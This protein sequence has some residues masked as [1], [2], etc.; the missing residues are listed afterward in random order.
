MRRQTRSTDNDKLPASS[1]SRASI[2]RLRSNPSRSVISTART[3]E[4]DKL[5]S[6]SSSRASITRLRSNPPR[7]VTLVVT[8]PSAASSST[9]TREVEDEGISCQE[10]SVGK[11]TEEEE[12]AKITIHNFIDEE[13][14][15]G[16]GGESDVDGD[17]FDIH[18]DSLVTH[19]EE[20]NDKFVEVD[21][22]DKKGR[23]I[24]FVDLT[25]EGSTKVVGKV[26]MLHDAD[27]E[28]VLEGAKKKSRSPVLHPI[29]RYL[30]LHQNEESQ[31]SQASI[32]QEIGHVI[33]LLLSSTI[34]KK[35]VNIYITLCLPVLNQFH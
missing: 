25:A 27:N 33:A 6:S 35:L 9:L 18:H 22:K 14:Y 20:S 5:P 19:S 13:Q 28:I 32:I 30:L 11:V 7:S 23:S 21:D 3:K 2:T 10:S 1:P 26:H 34:E 17:E 31:S 16:D 12:D 4:N 15:G 8:S 24:G 29:G